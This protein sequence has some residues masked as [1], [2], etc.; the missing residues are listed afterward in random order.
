MAKDVFISYAEEDELAARTICETLE[1]KG[2]FCWM[3]PRN[4]QP[5]GIWAEGIMDAISA[6]RVMVLVFSE[7]ANRSVYVQRE[8]QSAFDNGKTVIPFRLSNTKPT[9]LL[10]FFLK[11]VQWIDAFTQPTKEHSKTLAAHIRSLLSEGKTE[12]TD[13]ATMT[14][15]REEDYR[16]II[17]LQGIELTG[18]G[19]LTARLDLGATKGLLGPSTNSSDEVST[20]RKTHSLASIKCLA[21]KQVTSIF[22]FS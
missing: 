17:S 15:F 11:P 2:V 13:S 5:G 14:V 1:S 7:H 3:A 16:L 21:L 20:T 10:A 4:V 9:G 19:K 12:V 18:F 6:S 22:S 8:V